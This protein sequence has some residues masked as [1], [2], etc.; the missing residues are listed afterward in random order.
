MKQIKVMF[1]QMEAVS[2]EEVQDRLDGMFEVLFEE[3]L[4][5]LKENEEQRINNSVSGY[6]LPEN[7]FEVRSVC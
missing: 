7:R 3:T 6:A 4:Q 2:P 1:K 5:K